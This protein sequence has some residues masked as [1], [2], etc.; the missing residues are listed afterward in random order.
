MISNT[1]VT[2]ITSFYRRGLQ[3]DERDIMDYGLCTRFSTKPTYLP[4]E[5]KVFVLGKQPRLIWE[6]SMEL[7]M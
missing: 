2:K 7:D 3:D 4:A 6:I 1:R 5:I